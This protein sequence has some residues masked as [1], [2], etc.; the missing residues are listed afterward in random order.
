MV[1]EARQWCAE[2]FKRLASHYTETAHKTHL[3]YV[4]IELLKSWKECLHSNA[5]RDREQTVQNCTGLPPHLIYSSGS[6]GQFSGTNRQNGVRRRSGELAG[7]LC[8]S[9]PYRGKSP[10]GLDIYLIAL[11]F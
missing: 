6:E 9:L 5:I 3:M 11:R 10:N 2:T 7:S 1:I 8:V 4:F